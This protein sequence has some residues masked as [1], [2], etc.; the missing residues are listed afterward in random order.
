MENQRPL[1]VIV[2]GSLNMDLV[3]RVPRMPYH[4]ETLFG[5]SF[6]TF[7]GGKGYNQAVAAARSG[8]RVALIG[9]L[10]DDAFGDQFMEALE[11]E[12]IESRCVTRAE[13]TS[14]GIANILVELDGSN[15]IVIVSGA[16][17]LL[18]AAQVETAAPLFLNAK[19]LL[20]QLETSVE[21]AI[22]AASLA[23]KAGAKVIL[24]VAPVPLDPLPP[25]LLDLVDVLIM[26]ELEVFQLAGM[27]SN[28]PL[29]D[30]GMLERIPAQKLLEKGARNVLV[31]LG[32]RGAVYFAP[33][34]EPLYVPGFKV[35]VVDTTAA[36][37]AFT[38]TF[39][40]R[41]AE[42]LSMQ[43]A[44]WAGNVA[45]ALACSRPGAADSLPYDQEIEAFIKRVDN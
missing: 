29:D 37:D 1:E 14:T 28:V 36:G 19:V 10:G 16:N 38:G 9:K 23:R 17:A 42:G 22:A 35:N 5:E 11:K 13:N 44:I 27:S 4:H 20:L 18:D 31:T 33:D 40:S 12:N 45:G 3:L 6:N 41:L 39:A 25:K 26:N 32:A 30:Q 21:S 8:A 7:L 34:A 43:Q 24:T 2:A 15:R